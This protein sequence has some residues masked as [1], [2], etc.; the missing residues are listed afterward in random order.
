MTSVYLIGICGTAMATL[1]A[2]LKRQ[3]LH[4]RGSDAH[5]YPPMDGFLAAQG[6]TPLLGYDARHV[7]DDID[8]VVVGNAVSRGNPEVEA[9]LARRMHYVSLPEM[10]RDNFLRGRRS[11]VVAGT[12]GKTTTTSMLAW[13]LVEAHAD[14][15]F[16]VGGMPRNFDASFRLGRSDLFVIEGDEY[17]SA[18]FD[19]SAKFL[20]YLPFV[21]VVGNVEFDHADIYADLD[22]LRLAF[23]RLVGLVPGNGR[24]L[25]GADDEEARGLAAAAHCPVETF[26]VAP[27]A[28]WRA[29][30][31]SSRSGRTRFTV[32]HAG[33]HV[34]Q[35]D[36]PLI[37]AF[38]V[39]NAL[40]ATAAATAVGIPPEK[41]AAGLSTFRGVRRRLER[42][43]VARGVEVY[44]DFAHHPTAVRETLAAVRETAPAGRIWAVFEPRSATACRRVFQRAFAEALAVADRVV[45]GPVYRSSLSESERLSA[46][47]LAGD[48]AEA[49]V[50]ARHLDS[51]DDIVDIVGSEARDGDLI[52]VMSNGDFGGVHQR[53]LDRLAAAA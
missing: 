43:G 11:I 20:K 32:E 17:D 24:V 14:P 12:H 10:L 34:A 44:D 18:F 49:G 3:G 26:G 40:A 23:R 15:G 45:I 13:A 37:G 21:A 53:L 35:V 6:I 8:L 28:D 41:A 4:V 46:P 50:P 19:K 48:I 9:V 42:R 22:A 25:L 29:V 36:L 52:V 27:G 47:T 30:D 33:E 16:L 39:R 2:M 38:N 51:V 1:A 5:A 7:T 31:V